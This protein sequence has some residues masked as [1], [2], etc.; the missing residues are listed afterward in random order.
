M[1][2]P[3]PAPTISKSKFLSGF[4]CPL[5]L[6]TQYNDKDLI[7]PIDPGTQYVFDM[8]HTVGDLAKQLYPD[9]LEVPGSNDRPDL[10]AT[11][12]ATRALLQLRRP[13]FE[14]SFLSD[15]P[16][17]RRYLR[18][19]VLVPVADGAWDLV[20]VKSSTRV[21]DIN[22]WDVAF[23]AGALENAGLKLNRLFL[24][25]VDTS[26]VR[27]GPVEPKLLFQSD[28]IT[29]RARALMPRVPEMFARYAAEIRGARPEVPIGPHCRDPYHCALTDVCWRDVPE[30]HVT[31]FVRAGH[32][33][34]DWLQDGHTLITD[35]P[36][37]E[38]SAAQ[39]IQKAAVAAGRAH[40]DKPT[41]AR[42]LAALEYPLWY[43]DFESLNPAVPLFENTRPFQQ[44]PFQFSLHVQETQG[45]TPRHLEYLSTGKDDPRPGLVEALRAIGP[46]GTVLAFN[47]AFESQVL[48]ALGAAYPTYTAMTDDLRNRLRDLADPFRTFAVY[49]PAQHGSYS[50]KAV[51]PALTGGG[52]N[53]L[54]IA[55][56]Q[57]AGREW[58]NAVYGAGVTAE[59]KEAVMAALRAY[60]GRDTGA[61][62]EILEVLRGMV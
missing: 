62:V 52:Y 12:A 27:Q 19:D 7:P 55:D 30:H 5:L 35:V 6:W 48:A 54:V 25:H 16:D 26:Y 60:C 58:V 42:M 31:T 43:L 50:L 49:H 32:R 15:E 18:A 39:R 29:D 14:A 10:D 59:E 2:M 24:M 56:G 53:D 44:V 21:K 17:G 23:Q 22:V 1:A 28:D 36:D 51:L 61:M 34:F 33:A 4:Q 13:I 57:T 9:G 41:V 3:P 20:E 37:R 38:L 40:V 8:G 47:G 45:A 11:V 46:K